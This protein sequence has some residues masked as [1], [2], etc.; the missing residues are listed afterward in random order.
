MKNKTKITNVTPVSLNCMG[1]AC[2]SIFNTDNGKYIIIGKKLEDKDLSQAVKDKIG[3]GEIAI[4][5]PQELLG[6]LNK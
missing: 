4:E 6:E 3:D 1:V 5:I 2:P